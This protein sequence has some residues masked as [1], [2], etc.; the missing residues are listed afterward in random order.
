MQTK[1]FGQNPELAIN[2]KAVCIDFFGSKSQYIFPI[3]V[4]SGT[5]DVV[6]AA[7]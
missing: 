5:V 4:S 2:I 7:I 3:E 1:L 6:N